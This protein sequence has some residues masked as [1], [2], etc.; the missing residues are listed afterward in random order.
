MST[1]APPPILVASDGATDADLVRKLLGGEFDQIRVSTHADSH[2]LAA[3][4]Y[5]ERSA[6]TILS[7]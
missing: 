7:G 5:L 6:T 1:P 2:V 3:D 4:N